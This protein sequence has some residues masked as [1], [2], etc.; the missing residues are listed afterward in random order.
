MY[1][2]VGKSPCRRVDCERIA[3]AT[4]SD[5]PS[6]FCSH[7]WIENA[8]VAKSLVSG[9]HYLN[10]NNLGR[11]NLSKWYHLPLKHSAIFFVI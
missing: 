7:C 9:K 1:K 3:A 6:K 4:L 11:E 2:I 10:Q 5:Y 8:T